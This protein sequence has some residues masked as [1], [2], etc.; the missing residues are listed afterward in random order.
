MPQ[1]AASLTA[2]YPHPHKPLSLRLY[3]LTLILFLLSACTPKPN[4]TKAELLVF[5]TLVQITIYSSDQQRAQKAIQ[6]VE[7]R[8]QTFHHEWHAWEKG[9]IV[10]KINQSIANNQPIE[11]AN[12]VK[13]FILKSQQL[14]KQSDYLFDPGIGQLI[15]LWGFH[16]EQWSGPP[17]TA[18]K[19]SHWLRVRPS[20]ADLYFTGNQLYSRNPAVK[21]DFGGNAKGLALDIAIQQLR[22]AGI[23]NAI[24]NIGGDMRVIGSKNG[25][26]W[27]IGVQ[28]PAH[29]Q[30]AIAE[31]DLRGD[32]SIVTSGT[33]QRFFEWKGRRYSHILNPNSGYPAES[34]ASVTV[35]HP[36][37]TTADAA[38]TAL[39]IAGPEHW[40]EVAKKMGIDAVLVIDHN[41][42]IEQTK[43]MANHCKLL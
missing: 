41:G 11:V 20:I 10:S 16:S 33:Y 18:D 38:A 21:L 24:V 5:G 28:N 22:Q 19:I 3:C 36:D 32:M 17:P 39:L 35:M 25:Q 12:S 6:A 8:F 42:H 1:H 27:S 14:A 43:A 23:Q 4:A 30:Q 15:D 7:Q 29:P 2:A 26:A 40:K 9:G 34:L 37:A 31:I 13:D